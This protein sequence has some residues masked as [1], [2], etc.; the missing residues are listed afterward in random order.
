MLPPN[1]FARGPLTRELPPQTVLLGPLR[2][3]LLPPF[4]CWGLPRRGPPPKQLF[5]DLTGRSFFLLEFVWI[6]S[7]GRFP[8]VAFEFGRLNGEPPLQKVLHS[9]AAQI[10]SPLF[11]LL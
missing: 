10:S 11:L 2:W 9:L 6:L 8:F 5:E 1:I 7:G 4:G 3:D